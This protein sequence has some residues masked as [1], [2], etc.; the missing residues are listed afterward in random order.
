MSDT[1][2]YAVLV[3]VLWKPLAMN[4]IGPLIV[5]KMVKIPTDIRFPQVDEAAFSAGNPARS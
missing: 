4:T 3:F 5:W 2:L 1:L